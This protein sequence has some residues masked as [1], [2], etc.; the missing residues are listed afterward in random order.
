[1]ISLFHYISQIPHQHNSPPLI[2]FP[3]PIKPHTYSS[4]TLSSS[5]SASSSPSYPCFMFLH[6][7]HPD[8]FMPK[9]N[10]FQ[11]DVFH[12]LSELN[13]QRAYGPDGVPPIVLKNCAS[14]LPPCLIK[15]FRLC[16]SS[17]TFP[18]W[19]YAYIQPVPKEGN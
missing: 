6:H 13:P 2:L 18:C 11:N 10:I 9:V 3:N 14:V 4:D 1:M 7:T 16:L 15:L 17:S 8:Y 19:K 5:Y 12:T